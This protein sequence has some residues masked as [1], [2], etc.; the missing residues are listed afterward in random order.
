MK[1]WRMG[2]YTVIMTAILGGLYPLLIFAIG[3]I[4]FS[5]Q[6]NGSLIQD[7]KTG[8]PVGSEL[9]GQSFSLPCYL[10]PRPSAAGEMGYDATAS[11]GSLLAPSSSQ[12]VDLVKERVACYRAINH[13]NEDT[14][15]PPDAVMASGSGLDSDIT[16]EN[17]LLQAHRIAG[18]R[19]L[20]ERQVRSMM[21]EQSYHSKLRR[22]DPRRI[23][24]LK[25]N[26]LLD[27][28]ASCEKKEKQ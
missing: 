24:V 16:L 23:N 26:L 12:L 17:A 19:G 14:L 20:R 18:K 7:E 11:R 15:I 1:I 4:C 3:Q 8:R 21:R 13:L 9:I 10:Y 27:E 22:L 25:F 6:A 2:I 5:F 28:I